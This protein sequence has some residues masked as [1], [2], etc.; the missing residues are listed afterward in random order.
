MCPLLSKFS[1]ITIQNPLNQM[2]WDNT[3]LILQ[4]CYA[5]SLWTKESYN[6]DYLYISFGE[7]KC[8]TCE[9]HLGAHNRDEIIL[10]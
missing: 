4:T 9:I 3:V 10:K 1:L 2:G 5:S 8:L 7:A 6:E